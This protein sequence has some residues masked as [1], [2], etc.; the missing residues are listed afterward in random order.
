[1]VV[2]AGVLQMRYTG[3]FDILGTPW[4]ATPHLLIVLGITCTIV[5]FLGCCGA[6]R[7]NYCLTVSFAVLLSVILLAEFFGIIFAYSFHDS[8]K[9]NIEDQLQQGLSRYSRSRGVQMTW[10]ETQQQFQCC[11]VYNAS[12]WGENVPQSC[13]KY[14]I[15]GCSS[16]PQ[17]LL[18]EMGCT[19]A[20]EAWITQNVALIGA[21]AA[22]ATAIQIIGVCFACCL[23]KSILR[24][25]HDYYY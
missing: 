23:S 11:G 24:D 7:E 21:V 3:L 9:V 17:P 10:D 5:G 14:P 2:A 16:M 25:F 20:V 8:V 12:D 22:L 19:E 15:H 1:M 18:H 4:F 13:C 6:I